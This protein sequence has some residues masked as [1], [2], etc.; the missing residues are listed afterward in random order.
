MWATPLPEKEEFGRE[1]GDDSK[2]KLGPGKVIMG[3]TLTEG[4]KGQLIQIIKDFEDVFSEVP[5]RTRNAV[6]KIITPG[7][8][9]VRERW[10]WILY[11]PY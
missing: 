4:Q 2:E 9:I 10:R 5:D 8:N 3:G 6:H 1:L 7:G 11:H